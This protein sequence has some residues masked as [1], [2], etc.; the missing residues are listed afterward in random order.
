[1][2]ATG[3]T[4]Q[5]IKIAKASGQIDIVTSLSKLVPT[6]FVGQ[7][8]GAPGPDQV[9]T[10]RWMRAIFREI[11]LDLGNDPTFREQAHNAGK[12]LVAY[13][14][15]LVETRVSQRNAG[16]T[17]P[18]D[19][20]SRLVELQADDAE[21]TNQT[22]TRLVGGTIVGT[23]PTNN[24][25]IVQSL[26]VLLKHPVALSLASEAA[27]SGDTELVT[28]CIFE[29]LRY[30]PQNPLLL[31]HCIKDCVVAA[32]TKREKI[33]KAGSMVIVGTESAMFDEDKFPQPNEFMADRPMENYIHFGVGQHTC[34][35][36]I[37]ST[38]L[39]PAVLSP[40]IQLKNLRQA[41]GS[42]GKVKFDGAFPDHWTLA[43]DTE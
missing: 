41:E 40:L 15:D 8:F 14:T 3:I 28:Q 29:A 1:M 16:V 11:F 6:E 23:V 4:E 24:K 38:M 19:F 27:A 7:Y 31:R 43:F 20:L 39:W 18:D 9:T 32:G 5:Q 17:L 26:D 30:N 34:F 2:L 13:L 42:A 10:Q 37:I 22:I 12:E 35:G 21:L 33:I 36:K 25:A